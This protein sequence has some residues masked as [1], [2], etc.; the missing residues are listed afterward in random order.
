[1]T[2]WIAVALVFSIAVVV[3][4]VFFGPETVVPVDGGND[5]VAGDAQTGIAVESPPAVETGPAP[6]P[7]DAGT[8][9]FRIGPEYDAALAGGIA[10]ALGEAGYRSVRVETLPFDVAQSRVGY[11]REQDR[12]AAL[13]LARRVEAMAEGSGG[14]EVQD[15]GG[16]LDA[17]EPGRLDLWLGGQGKDGS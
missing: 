5:V 3:A 9:R 11:Y 2:A 7:A 12:G 14:I 13:A 4:A 1:M 6:E 10:A 15:Y 17:T 16:M 8:I